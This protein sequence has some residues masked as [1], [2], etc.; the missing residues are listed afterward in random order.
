MIFAGLSRFSRT[1]HVPPYALIAATAL[2]R[3]IS[4]ASCG[5]YI[6][7]SCGNV[8]SVRVQRLY[9]NHDPRPHDPLFAH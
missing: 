8:R 1:R 7:F 6:A 5:I 2:L 4:F 9:F 3:V